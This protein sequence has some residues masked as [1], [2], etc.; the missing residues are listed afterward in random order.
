M[1]SS[2]PPNAAAFC[3]LAISDRALPEGAGE[4]T[5]GAKAT[6]TTRFGTQLH[7]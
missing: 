5:E 1:M 2:F 4:K 7:D 6:S 3:N